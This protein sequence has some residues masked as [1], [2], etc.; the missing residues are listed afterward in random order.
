MAA[1]IEKL[2]RAQKNFILLHDG[3]K[4]LLWD[5]SR[6]ITTDFLFRLKRL[7]IIS[8]R[9]GRWHGMSRL[10][11]KGQKILTALRA[12]SHKGSSND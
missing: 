5:T 1:E 3:D 4:P 8:R 10:T 7:G 2:T 9:S 11:L 12:L 6:R